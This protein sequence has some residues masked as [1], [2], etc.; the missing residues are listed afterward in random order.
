MT[1][2]ETDTETKVCEACSKPLWPIVNDAGKNVGWQHTPEGN[3]HH[4]QVTGEYH[5]PFPHAPLQESDLDMCSGCNHPRA[6]HAQWP[7]GPTCSG[8]DDVTIE[9]DDCLCDGFKE[10]T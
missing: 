9:H 8:F 5:Q 10:A 3:D 6:L 1:P 2:E 7:S 4:R